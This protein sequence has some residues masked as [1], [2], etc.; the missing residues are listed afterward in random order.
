MGKK[1]VTTSTLK[2]M[3]IEK[4]PIV[5]VTAYDYPSALLS[6]QA[7]VDVIL[8]GDSLGM[9]VLGYDST[10]P[11]TLDD[12]V[13]HTRAV[14]RG[15]R[16]PLI[17][18]DMPFLSYHG[19]I[20]KTLQNA[21]RLLQDGGATAIKMEGGKDI[22]PM[23][24]ACVKAGIPVMGHIGL[25]PQSINQLGGYKVQGKNEEEAKRL[26]EDALL[27]EEAGVFSVV[28]E[29]VPYQLAREISN[30]LMI[31][32]IGIGAGPYCDGQVLVFHDIL[33][34]GSNLSPKFVKPYASVGE[35]VKGAIELYAKEVRERKFPELTHSFSADYGTNDKMG[36]KDVALYGG[37]QK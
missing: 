37:N 27:L 23:V 19:T 26:I 7:G 2:K 1:G 8:V 25:T 30:Q 12:M 18:S 13:H 33:Q 29:C 16:N 6:E 20:D 32:T 9:V 36:T 5:M 28:L 21:G 15:A 17:V 22:L 4:K 14:C 34:Y 3:K 24:E 31:P 11:V 35:Q 10:I